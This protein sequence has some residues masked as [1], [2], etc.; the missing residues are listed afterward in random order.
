MSDT[1][2]KPVEQFVLPPSVV[3]KVDLSR[4]VAEAERVDNELTTAAVRAKS[5]VGQQAQVR[6]SAPLTDFLSQNTLTLDDAHARTGLIKQL[7][8]LKDSAPVVHMTFA[9]AADSESLQQLVQWLR[10]SVHPQA[11]I[12]VGL[13]PALVA[14]VYVRTT[15][16]VHDMSLRAK[17]ASSRGLLLKELETLR[18][19]R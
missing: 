18:V 1:V 8:Q 2:V 3:D 12:A 6:L 19:S 10:Q 14:G 13:Q 7:H 5:G 11:V 17:L 16:H 15:N 9:T 4:L